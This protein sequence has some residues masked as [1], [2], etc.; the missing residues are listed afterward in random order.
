MYHKVHSERATKNYSE[1]PVRRE[2]SCIILL[3]VE[4]WMINWH[5]LA[6]TRKGGGASCDSQHY[7]QVADLHLSPH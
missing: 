3:E 7:T 2:G 1:Y 6:I 4:R 5:I